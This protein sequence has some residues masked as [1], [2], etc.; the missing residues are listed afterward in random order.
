M[1]DK[2]LEDAAKRVSDTYA[3]HKSADPLGSIGK[4]F[5]VAMSDGTSDGVLYDTRQ[6][7][8]AHQH[9]N[10]M[11]YAYL[12]VTPG[13]LRTVRECKMWLVATR[14]MYDAGFRMTD[15]NARGGGRELI[16]RATVED[17]RSLIRSL[18]QGTK[19][20]NLISPN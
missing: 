16:K 9:H 8:V 2:Q 15:P 19:P 6:E 1:N 14:K 18:F 20:S 7:C 10:E 12:Q 17:Q 11:Y 5:A 3:L 4:W 13:S